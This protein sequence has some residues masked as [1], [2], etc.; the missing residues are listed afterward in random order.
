MYIKTCLPFAEID[1]SGNVNV[2]GE[3]RPAVQYVCVS[4][5]CMYISGTGGGTGDGSLYHSLVQ[6]ISSRS[7]RF[8]WVVQGTVP[9]TLYHP[10]SLTF[11]RHQIPDLIR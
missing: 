6:L 10:L 8:A 4:Y 9:C 2:L 5:M 1:E 3:C 7:S 11:S